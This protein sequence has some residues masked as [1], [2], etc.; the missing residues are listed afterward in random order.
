[1]KR[2]L[3]SRDISE[4]QASSHSSTKNRMTAGML[5]DLLEQR[6]S[7]TSRSELSSLVGRYDIEPAVLERVATIVNTPSV[8]EGSRR[9]IL[10]D[11]GR[12]RW[13]MLVR[14]LDL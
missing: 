10:E 2:V 6:R 11:D 4:Q 7:I 8:A 3:H 9:K 5:F 12:E 1:M 13:T 14:S